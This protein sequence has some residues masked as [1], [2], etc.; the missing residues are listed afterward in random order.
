[1]VP[2]QSLET[3]SPADPSLMYSMSYCYSTFGAPAILV[4]GGVVRGEEHRRQGGALWAW[5]HYA[6][7]FDAGYYGVDAYGLA[8]FHQDLGDHAGGGRGDL[9]VHLVG[10]DFE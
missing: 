8:L 10:G 1:M 2:R 3:F 4:A 5:R 9:G 6:A 7:L